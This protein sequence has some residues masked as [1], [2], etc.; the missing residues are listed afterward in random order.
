MPCIN[1]QHTDQPLPPRDVELSFHGSINLIKPI[2]EAAQDWIDENVAEGALFFGRALAVE[3][4]YAD[5]IVEGMIDDGLAVYIGDGY[6]QR[7]IR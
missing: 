4:R 7:I 6:L 1:A 5:D 3:P 2:T